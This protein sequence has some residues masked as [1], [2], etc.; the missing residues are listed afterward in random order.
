MMHYDENGFVEFREFSTA[1]IIRACDIRLKAIGEAKSKIRRLFVAD[2]VDKGRRKWEQSRFK[3]FFRPMTRRKALT[4]YYGVSR[5]A[6][7][8]V[9][10]YIKVKLKYL[11]LENDLKRLLRAAKSVNNG[12]MS[13]SNDMAKRCDLI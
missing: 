9:Y 11:P 4:A 10:P 2:R 3:W 5:D 1:A 12:V 13:I 7:V 8:F 6:Y